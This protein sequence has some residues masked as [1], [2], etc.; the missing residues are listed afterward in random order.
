M[1]TGILVHGLTQS[2]VQKGAADQSQWGAGLWRM[3]QEMPSI[4]P[5]QKYA[6]LHAV[7]LGSALGRAEMRPGAGQGVFRPFL[8]KP[9]LQFSAFMGVRIT[10]LVLLQ[11]CFITQ[12]GCNPVSLA[13]VYGHRARFWL[14]DCECILF[15]PCWAISGSFLFCRPNGSQRRQP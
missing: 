8:V 6:S 12:L 14:K 2:S 3:Y 5:V 4:L 1:L 11:S 10:R 13:M 9:R 7:S 15:Q